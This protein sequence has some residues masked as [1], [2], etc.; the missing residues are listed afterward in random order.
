LKLVGAIGWLVV[1]RG[2]VIWRHVVTIGMIIWEPT[3]NSVP[4]GYT[5]NCFMLIDNGANL[6]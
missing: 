6:M 3:G 4:L 5:N 1:V 2:S